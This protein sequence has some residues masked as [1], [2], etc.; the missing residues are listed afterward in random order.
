M[1]TF[2][3]VCMG[4]GRECQGQALTGDILGTVRDAS[5]AVITDA[6]VKL[7][8]VGAAVTFSTTTDASGNY[9]F[10]QLQP[11]HYSLAVSKANF[12]KTAMTDIEL[13][14]AQH[15]QLD[16]TLSVGSAT[17]QIQVSAGAAELL[18]TQTAEVGQVVQ[19]KP[20]VE[21]P[22][23]GRDFIQLATLAPGV[24]PVG[25]AYSCVSAGYGTGASQGTVTFVAMG[26]RESD[27]SYL[28]DGIETRGARFG[29]ATIRPS[30]DAIQEFK[31][32]TQDYGADNGRSSIIV[33]LALKSG[34]DTL[35]GSAYE[36]LRNSV[37]DANNFFLNLAG[38]RKP[39]F[40]QNDFGVSLGGPVRRGKT[41]F[42]GDYEGIRSLKA[43]SLLG[44]Y[45]SAA[46]LAGNL[47]DD[48]TGTGI[49]PTASSFCQANPGSTKC[50]DVIDPFTRAPFPNNQIPSSTLDPIAQKWLPY[51]NKPNVA[52]TPN[53]AALPSFNFATTPKERNNAD[54]FH[55][56]IDHQ[57]SE[58]DHMFG[59]YSFDQRPHFVPGLAILGGETFPWR[60]QVLALSETHLFSTNVVND[61]HFGYSRSRNGGIA[62]TAFGPNIAADV[63]GFQNVP[64]RPI[65][66][67]VPTA[68]ISGFSSVGSYNIPEDSLD[69]SF[70]FIDNLSIARGKHT[71]KMGA[72][73]SHEK[74]IYI[75]DC[76]ATPTFAFD[77]R[78]SGA[79]LADFL[80]GI[81]DNSTQSVGE[82]NLNSTAD[83][84][85]GYFEDDIR[86]RS[87]L[88]L[89]LG[90]R[91]EYQQSP[92]AI[93][94]REE[95]FLPSTGQEAAV[96]RNQI[97]NGLVNPDYKDW[98]PRVGIAYS[99]FRNTVIR[100]S[101]GIFYGTGNWNEFGFAAF[102]PDFIINQ[103]LSS[104][105]TAPS[106]FLKDV[107]PA[108][109]LGPQNQ[110]PNIGSFGVD[111]KNRTPYVQEWSLDVQHTFG[112]SW[113]VDIGYAGNVGQ[114]LQT[115]RD[116]NTPTFDPTGTIPIA[117]RRPFSNF[118]YILTTSSIGW[119]SYNALLAKLE[120]KVT[121]NSFVLASY[122]WAKT[123][124][125]FIPGYGE[126]ASRD[127]KVFDKGNS[128]FEVPQ[129]F[130]LTYS[131]SLPIGKNM[132]FWSGASGFAGK[133]VS[134]WTV[135][136]ITTFQSGHYQIPTLPFD[137]VNLGPFS[138]S[139]PDRVGPVVPAHRSYNNWWNSSA[140]ALPGC[141]SLTPCSTQVHLEGN[142]RKGTIENPGMNNWD[143]SV[144]KDTVVR[145]RLRLQ[146]RAELF[147]AWNHVQFGP[148]NS[149]LTPGVFGQ[150]TS[151][152]IPPREIQFGLKLLW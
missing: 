22:L 6:Q 50:L 38:V 88:T 143:I 128:L 136:G 52:T 19:Q 103:S 56:R 131:Y 116:D 81:P 15:Q 149:S 20:I 29:N 117:Q 39:G 144:E 44:L 127:I 70:Q 41:F 66:F 76:A 33:N 134:G 101:F 107:F 141:P 112:N 2:V 114:H 42:F 48:S 89:N 83:F 87:T 23:N 97:R 43:Q 108:I 102:G 147:N 8:Q 10:S 75:C 99:P 79:G 113:L 67:G 18:E 49:L 96:F 133:L 145:E 11:A 95:T 150:I 80:L 59:S 137:Y 40:Q 53:Q 27:I 54:L 64:N 1:A 124:D 121:S 73:F 36:F 62:Q 13:H 69:R 45:P 34:S 77:G 16:I 146:F 91:Y 90:V 7:T 17:E 85:A 142:A 98:G 72:T 140:F 111:P 74:F 4:F 46:Q 106:V 152:L 84:Y 51:V 126:V 119:S 109:Q 65:A 5:G 9:R 14:V 61:F 118:S 71:L 60:A 82:G 139:L 104:N 110:G 37:F 12:E 92:Q 93:N 26:L 31:V 78:F 129:R 122:T 28:V 3:L 21:L 115:R 35:H 86:V 55:I 105:P 30:P 94:G 57:F 148:P 47:A 130:S 25:S 135:N 132:R 68:G 100:S 58:K 123:L 120:K 125:T 138:T 32:Q 24:Y 151:L 63:F